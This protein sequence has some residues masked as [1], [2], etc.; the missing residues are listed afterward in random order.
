MFAHVCVDVSN[1]HALSQK[2]KQKQKQQW[3]QVSGEWIDVMLKV[4][5]FVTD[6]ILFTGL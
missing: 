2:N 4:K 5:L 3:V 1:S 6:Y